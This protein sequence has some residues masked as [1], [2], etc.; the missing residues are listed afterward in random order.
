MTVKM[1]LYKNQMPLFYLAVARCA[2]LH[3]KRFWVTLN[4]TRLYPLFGLTKVQKAS[5]FAA[6]SPCVSISRSHSG[7]ALAR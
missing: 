3:T 6:R 7:A 4:Y 2:I 1:K 5:K